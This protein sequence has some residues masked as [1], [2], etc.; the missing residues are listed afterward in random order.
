M[1]FSPPQSLTPSPPPSTFSVSLLPAVT[2]LRERRK[3]KELSS[4][5]S[6]LFPSSSLLS[7]EQFSLVSSS[8]IALTDAID[9]LN[10]FGPKH[11]LS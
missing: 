6:P 2:T 10:S 1:S 8:T 11:V 9:S 3:A 5:T 4:P 7:P